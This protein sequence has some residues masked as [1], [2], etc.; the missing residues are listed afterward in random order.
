[1]RARVWT[2]SRPA[3]HLRENGQHVDHGQR[4][5]DLLRFRSTPAACRARQAPP[6]AGHVAGGAAVLPAVG[7]SAGLLVGGDFGERLAAAVDR[8]VSNLPSAA[9]AGDHLAFGG[10]R[11]S[12]GRQIPG[13]V[14]VE[15]TVPVTPLAFFGP[16]GVVR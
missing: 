9:T 13:A 1:M 3:Q 6:R 8:Q 16:R 4:R 15:V 2:S 12:A 5:G 14:A 7:S 10:E 11:G